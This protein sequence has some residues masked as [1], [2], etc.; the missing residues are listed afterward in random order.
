MC[1]SAMRSGHG[2][3]LA[4]L[5]VTTMLLVARPSMG[6]SSLEQVLEAVPVSSPSRGVFLVAEQ[7]MPDPRFRGTVV[8]LLEH[9]DSGSLGVIINRATAVSLGEAVPDLAAT[10][11]RTQPMF[12]GG[13]VALDTMLFLIRSEAGLA[14]A[15]RVLEDVYHSASRSALEE[16]LQR[17]TGT[18]EMRFFVG[19]SGWGPG[20]L[21]T[22]L[23]RQDWRLFRGPAHILFHGDNAS[24][25]Q[26]FM[27]HSGRLLVRHSPTRIDP[28]F[29]DLVAATRPS[30]GPQ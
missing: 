5:G 23:S 20:Q 25:W 4:W 13:P 21:E 18:E 16:V 11:Y 29:S 7:S 28:R 14:N 8:L 1:I 27:T 10:S 12:F 19:Y 17:G 15:N 24:L 22:E 9:D 26:R 2:L 6:S 30:G 3:S